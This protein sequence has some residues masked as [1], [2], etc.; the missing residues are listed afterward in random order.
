MIYIYFNFFILFLYILF[1]G[2]IDSCYE[3]SRY[4]LQVLSFMKNMF[5]P[6]IFYYDRKQLLIS[7]DIFIV[8]FGSDS[9]T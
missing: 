1:F 6:G 3:Y 2:I 8:S 7:W 5:L 9:Y 4:T